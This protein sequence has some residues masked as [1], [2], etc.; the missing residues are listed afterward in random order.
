MSEALFQQA[1]YAA[2]RHETET[3]LELCRQLLEQNPAHLQGWL[4][5]CRMQR[6]S[7]QMDAALISAQKALTLAPKVAESHAEAAAT[8]YAMRNYYPAVQHYY[9]AHELAPQ[10]A[11]YPFQLGIIM[12][13]LTKFDE[14]IQCQ[15]KA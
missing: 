5:Q 1:Q 12:Q 6:E 14:A 8:Y 3:A 13:S 11:E 4:L 15:M 7:Q 2:A 9:K 10:V